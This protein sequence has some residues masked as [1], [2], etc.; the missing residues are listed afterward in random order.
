MGSYCQESTGEEKKIN[1][2]AY[3]PPTMHEFHK[4]SIVSVMYSTRNMAKAGKH[5]RGWERPTG[6]TVN[7]AE[8]QQFGR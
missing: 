4:Q 7:K 5:N 8:Q 1:A 3:L 6:E 2:G